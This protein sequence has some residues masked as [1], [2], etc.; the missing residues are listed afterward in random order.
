MENYKKQIPIKTET[1]SLIDD[2]KQVTVS[3]N[4]YFESKTNKLNA[5]KLLLD[6]NY[7]IQNIH[8]EKGKEQMN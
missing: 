6:I 7:Y 1:K 2:P 3:L 8:L 4:E 5:N